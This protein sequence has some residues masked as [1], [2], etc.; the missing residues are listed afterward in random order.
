MDKFNFSYNQPTTSEA[1]AN[2]DNSD[3]DEIDEI[4]TFKEE[5]NGNKYNKLTKKYIIN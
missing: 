1:E 3:I 5:T 4:D 2:S